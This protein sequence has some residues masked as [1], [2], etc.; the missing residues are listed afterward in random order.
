MIFMEINPFIYNSPNVAPY[1]VLP[2]LV[3]LCC[4]WDC[5]VDD[6]TE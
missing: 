2:H 1:A 4:D 3:L 6:R 5:L